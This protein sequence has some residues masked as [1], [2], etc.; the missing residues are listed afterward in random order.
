[1]RGL[2]VVPGTAGSVRFD[3]LSQPKPGVD[4]LLVGGIAAG[5]CCTDREIV[6]GA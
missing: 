1:M 3:D 5:G 4:E 2:T 6:A